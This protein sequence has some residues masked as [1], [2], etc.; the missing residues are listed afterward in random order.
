MSSN[1]KLIEPGVKYFLRKSLKN[2]YIVKKNYY[3][4]VF[5]I[6]LLL[7][8][9]FILGSF[10]IYKK[11][12]KITETDRRTNIEISKNYLLEKIRKISAEKKKQKEEL[13]T[14]IPKFESSFVQLHKK[15][16]TI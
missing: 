8:L 2:C 7:F 16:Y 14:N 1:P 4:V 6:S 13:I 9:I 15:Y 11:K 3:Y 12:Y 10:L 5:N